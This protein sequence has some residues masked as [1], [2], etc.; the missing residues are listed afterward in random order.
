MRFNRLQIHVLSLLIQKRAYFHHLLLEIHSFSLSLRKNRLK[1][2]KIGDLVV[3][4]ETPE[5]LMIRSRDLIRKEMN[6][7][8]TYRID[9]HIDYESYF[10]Y[11]SMVIYCKI[12]SKWLWTDL[13]KKKRRPQAKKSA[14]VKP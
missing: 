4:F 7:S 5:I 8:H 9:L 12:P 14:T 6:M 13:S 11:Q 1:C 10:L 2:V 3:L